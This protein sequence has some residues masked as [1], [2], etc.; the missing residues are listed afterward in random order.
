[1]SCQNNSALLDKA[2]ETF[3]TLFTGFFSAV[4]A[5]HPSI[6]PFVPTG[7]GGGDGNTVTADDGGNR[8]IA[9]LN[10]SKSSK[11]A[12]LH[13]DTSLHSAASAVHRKDSR[14]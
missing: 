5:D 13:D 10:L 11:N 9:R 8:P 2:F 6:I 7:G 12:D 3:S 1:M 4:S 14:R